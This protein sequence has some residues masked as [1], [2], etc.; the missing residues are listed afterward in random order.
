MWVAVWCNLIV[1]N[2]TWW[3]NVWARPHSSSAENDW[4]NTL[5]III[6][7]LTKSGADRCKSVNEKTLIIEQ[8]K[9][10]ADTCRCKS[11][12]EGIT[13]WISG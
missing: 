8:I 13:E 7:G 4:Q 9:S 1:H 6:I 10:G 12:N 2:C 11:V 3:K 5:I